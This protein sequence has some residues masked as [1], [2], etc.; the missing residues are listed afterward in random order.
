MNVG[1][2]GHV[3]WIEFVRVERVPEAG[4]IVQAR[5]TWQEPAGG[6]GVAAVELARLAASSTLFTALGDDDVGRR[7]QEELERLGIRV[8]AAFR[9][10]PQRRGFVYVDDEG[11][12]TITVI[13]EKLRPRRD[14]PLPW[15][16]LAEFDA[17][18]FTAGTPDA[19]RAARAA[20]VLV[21]TARE[22]PT[23]VEAGVALDA[24]VGSAD[25]PSERY[26]GELDPEP[27][28][29][30]RTAGSRGGTYEPGSGTW[31]AAALPGPFVD[32]YGAG[33][34]FAAALTFALGEGRDVDHALAFAAQRG[35]AALARRGAH[36]AAVSP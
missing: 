7:V 18:Y 25:D 19:V 1:V 24:L 31:S 26:G 13:G 27:R 15:E 6:G 11:E 10:E 3:E 32:T 12:R 22:L 20:R 29:V 14:E 23:L 34:S 33:D 35:A 8:E 16:E 28:L 30:V 9:D 5:E 17:I 36:G 4:E 21:A 2:V